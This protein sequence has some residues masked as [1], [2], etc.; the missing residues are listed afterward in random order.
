MA[1]IPRAQ[2]FSIQTPL[3]YRESGDSTWQEGETVNISRTGVLFRTQRTIASRTPLELSFELPIEVAS[4][5][6]A[7]VICQ[8]EVVRTVM[9]PTSDDAAAVAAR[10][11]EYQLARVPDEQ[12]LEG[13]REKQ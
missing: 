4:L 12:G 2:R 8:G 13:G 1:G 11:L 10:I 5:S 9:P 7:T 3:R 6:G